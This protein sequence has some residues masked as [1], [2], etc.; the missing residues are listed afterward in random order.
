ML[1]HPSGHVSRGNDLGH[2]EIP[3][4]Q[5]IHR[6]V[7]V[8]SFVLI[9]NA[10]DDDDSAANKA[11]GVKVGGWKDFF[12]ISVNLSRPT[13]AEHNDI[14]INAEIRI[15]EILVL[16]TDAHEASIGQSGLGGSQAV[17]GPSWAVRAIEFDVEQL[18]N[19]KRCAHAQQ[20]AFFEIPAFLSVVTTNHPLPKL[21]AHSLGILIP[22]SGRSLLRERFSRD[23]C[24]Q[25]QKPN[26]GL[27]L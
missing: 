12:R 21:H 11:C 2:V 5:A 9:P 14:V 20:P 6:R 17:K 24:H 16:A 10:T 7:P 15:I 26:A 22:E 19:S 8:A 18:T 25:I 4:I 1:R 27:P 13:R 3:D 23:F